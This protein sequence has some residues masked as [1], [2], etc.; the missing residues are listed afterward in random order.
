MW[1]VA[2]LQT[3]AAQHV[4]T[5]VHQAPLEDALVSGQGRPQR[6]ESETGWSDIDVSTC[7]R[8][9][10]AATQSKPLRRLARPSLAYIRSVIMW[11]LSLL[12]GL[13]V[14]GA[15]P[16]VLRLSP[17]P[18]RSACTLAVRNAGLPCRL[19]G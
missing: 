5:D 7:I 8:G 2:P 10:L 14:A 13:V 19:G 18:V 9:G 17:P 4:H 15:L 6:C 3:A 16:S 12:A 1:M 11:L